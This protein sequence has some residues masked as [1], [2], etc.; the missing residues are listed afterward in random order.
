MNFS[1]YRYTTVAIIMLW[2]LGGCTSTPS[3]QYYALLADTSI[4]PPTTPI[5]SD[6]FALGIGP[7]VIPDM[8]DNIGIISIDKGNKVSVATYDVWAGNLKDNINQVLADNIANLLGADSVWAYP[9]DNRNRPKT[10]LR[11]IFERFIGEKNKSITLQAKWTL[12]TNYGRKE[13]KTQKSIITLPVKG[14]SYSDYTHA[15]NQALNE[16]SKELT[17]EIHYLNSAL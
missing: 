3:T 5:V 12:L 10:Q 4:T 13:L 14:D 16:L 1:H 6:T 17:E 8:L 11:I 2:L 15:L 7:I 9:W